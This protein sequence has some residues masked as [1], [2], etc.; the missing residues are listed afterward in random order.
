[1]I[2]YCATLVVPAS[3]LAQV[4]GW[5]AAHR[6]AHDARPWQRAA[7]RY[8]Q[9][10]LVLRWYQ[11]QGHTDLGPRWA[12]NRRRRGLRESSVRAVDDQHLSVQLNEVGLRKR[13]C[14]LLESTVEQREQVVIADVSGRDEQQSRR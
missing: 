6:R 14:D 8:V 5:L 10:V 4:S 12:W 9:A 11:Y 7:T 3:T 2:T 1:M 13:G